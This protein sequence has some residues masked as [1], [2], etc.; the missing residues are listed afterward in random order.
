MKLQC[1]TS[2]GVP[3]GSYLAKLVAI[4]QVPADSGKGFGPGFRWEFEIA[5]GPLTGTKTSGITSGMKPSPKNKLGRFVAG[6]TGKPIADG[7]IDLSSCLGKVFLIVVAAP[8]GAA[9]RVESVS[10]P[11]SA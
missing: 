9:T 4:S 7:E 6:V 11:P 2:T 1:T 8:G 5:T 10:L 3:P